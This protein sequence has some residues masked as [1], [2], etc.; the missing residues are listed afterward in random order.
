MVEIVKIEEKISSKLGFRDSA[1]DLFHYLNTLPVGKI[2]ID[3][4]GVEFISRSFA[5]EY[6]MQK[7]R[8]N[9]KIKNVNV[10]KNVKVMFDTVLK[11]IENPKK[12]KVNAKRVLA[13]S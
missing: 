7:N 5:H 1:E 13:F 2:F 9:K 12:N 11:S 10:P 4:T 6:L 8:T 3:F